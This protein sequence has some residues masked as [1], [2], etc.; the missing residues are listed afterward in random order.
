MP[1]LNQL[2]MLAYGQ[3]PDTTTSA[4]QMDSSG[5]LKS[6]LVQGGLDVG[7][8]NPVWVQGTV[9]AS[10]ATLNII[11]GLSTT[12]YDL[13][14]A[15]YS[16]TSAISGPYILNCIKF[17]FSAAV[18]KDITVTDV[19]TGTVLLSYTADTR[20]D[21]VAPAGD[22]GFP[23]GNQ[24]KVDISATASACTVTFSAEV[25]NGMLP[26]GGNPVLASPAAN[27]YI[28]DISV[29]DGRMLD[30]GGRLRVSNLQTIGEFKHLVNIGDLIFGNYGTGTSTWN[31]NTAS[32]TLATGST[33]SGVKQTQIKHAPVPYQPAKGQLTKITGVF[34]AEVVNVAKRMGVASALDKADGVW[35][36]QNGTSGPQFVIS[37]STS[38]SAVQT[39]IPQSGWNV[40]RFDGTGG[41]F[42]PSGLT[43]DLTKNT[44]FVPDF[45]WL[46][47]G[48]IRLGFEIGGIWHPAHYI[49]TSNVSALPF[50]RTPNFRPF[51][52]IENTGT[53]GAAASMLSLCTSTLSEGG[54]DIIGHSYAVATPDTAAS[55]PGTAMVPLLAVRPSLTYNSHPNQIIS[56]LREFSL[57]STQDG[58][59]EIIYY[60][61]F[62]GGTW[63]AVGGE[64]SM[65]YS[66][67][68]T[69]TGGQVFDTDFIQAT[70]KSAVFNQNITEIAEI[71]SLTG[72]DTGQIGFAVQ[73]NN[74]GSSAADVRAALRWLE[75]Y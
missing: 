43:L 6:A 25:Q 41:A 75:Q 38:G 34:G 3:K 12:A 67:N 31:Y 60:P 55:I 5:N 54:R 64:S 26:M 14:A 73:C 72:D 29:A 70:S 50:T 33:A 49:Q 57:Y 44:L 10:G 39:A 9:S 23:S 66:T 68:P 30:A 47:A 71:M 61:T 51:W 27:T 62:T 74:L 59:Y 11:S 16:G 52:E 56:T 35:L 21:F 18:S 8:A 7:S 42:N 2:L 37:T 69:F 22:Y 36:E 28:G 32:V 15:P 19:T 17:H 4:A 46:S 58:R 40:D 20:T 1:T 24:F 13:N 53:A 48:R 63:T 45:Q 65:E